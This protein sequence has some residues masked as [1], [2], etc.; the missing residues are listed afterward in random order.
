MSGDIPATCGAPSISSLDVLIQ[1]CTRHA[2][3]YLKTM[4]SRLPNC[5]MVCDRSPVQDGLVH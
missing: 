3:V 1:L 4:L 2:H 5:V